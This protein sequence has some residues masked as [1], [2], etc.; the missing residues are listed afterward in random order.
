MIGT[1]FIARFERFCPQ[2]LAEV[3]DPV[4]LHIGTLDKPVK[5]VL[6]TLDVRP[7]VV[8]GAIFQKIDLIVAK[9]PPIFSPVSRLTDDNPQTKMY[10][11]L[12]RHN[13][14][15]YAAHTN[16]DIVENGLNDWFCEALG[17]TVDNFLAPTAEVPYGKMN[18]DLPE[19]PESLLTALNRLN[20]FIDQQ[21]GRQEII[22]P[23]AD[24][25]EIEE[26]FQT[27]QIKILAQSSFIKEFGLGRVGHLEQTV[28]LENFAKKVKKTFDVKDL[29]LIA[30]NP[31]KMVEKVAICGGSGQKF[32]H[33][34]LKQNAD[35]YIT[36]DVYYHTGHDMLA[37]H[38]PVIDPGHYIESFCKEKLADLF[39]TW[40]TQENWDVEFIVSQVNTNPFTII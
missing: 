28:T 10:N 29:R 24:L 17:V 25:T 36:G 1:E 27:L 32:Y 9:H 8:S 34:A 12:I 16:L 5:K 38:M 35:V 14:A 30:E 39:N 21:E 6:I 31:Q 18:F 11:D 13:I 20:I 23:R 37:D 40:K 2:S 15:V 33:D 3:G 19:K 26:L 7:E 22:F 4:G